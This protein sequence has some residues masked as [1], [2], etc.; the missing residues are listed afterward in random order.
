LD[1]VA[2]PHY[3]KIVVDGIIGYS[4][5]IGLR[6]VLYSESAEYSAVLS[7]DPK[8]Y[9]KKKGKRTIECELMSIWSLSAISH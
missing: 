1:L 8:A 7:S 5:T 6:A 4:D 3:R 2:S 9:D